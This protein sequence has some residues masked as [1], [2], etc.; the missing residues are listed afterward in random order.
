[1]PSSTI[2]AKRLPLATSATETIEFVGGG[3]IIDD[4]ASAA[5][6]IILALESA[7]ASIAT[8]PKFAV[9]VGAAPSTGIDVA[10]VNDDISADVVAPV[11][12]NEGSK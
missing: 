5:A 3:S 8:S 11:A 10:V 4:T 9:G 6:A 7:V 12:A 2:T 1:M